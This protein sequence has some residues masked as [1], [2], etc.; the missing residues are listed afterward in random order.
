VQSRPIDEQRE[1]CGEK[2]LDDIVMTDCE[3]ERFR[4][5]FNAICLFQKTGQIRYIVKRNCLSNVI[6]INILP[7]SHIDMMTEFLLSYFILSKFDTRRCRKNISR[8]I[9]RYFENLS[10]KIFSIANLLTKYKI[11]MLSYVVAT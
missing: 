2:N 5:K 7:L 8:K 3:S 4:I 11:V 10:I 6:R 1:K 9:L